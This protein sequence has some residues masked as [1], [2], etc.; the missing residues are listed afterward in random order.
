MAAPAPPSPYLD[1]APFLRY[2]DPGERALVL[3]FA[4]GAGVIEP[5]LSSLGRQLAEELAATLRVHAGFVTLAQNLVAF[6]DGVGGGDDADARPTLKRP[7][8]AVFHS[9]PQ[10][11][12][13]RDVCRRFGASLALTGRL[14]ADGPEL[15]LGLNLIDVERL[16]LLASLH[17]VFTRDA[18][19]A[20]LVEASADLLARFVELPREALLARA[21]EVVGTQSYR[22]L[23]NWAMARD[24]ERQADIDGASAAVGK[25]GTRLLERLLYALED[26][27]LYLPPLDALIRYAA[28][29]HADRD[30][31][32]LR[33]LA[34]G[35]AKVRLVRPAFGMLVAEAWRAVGETAQA[36]EA[37][38]GLVRVFPKTAQAHF[39][40]GLFEEKERPKIAHQHF[41]EALKLDPTRELY[42]RKVYPASE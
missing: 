17:R 14:L 15:S 16:T 34:K 21:A 11:R 35:L 39:M 3:C 27:P 33:Q 38:E 2:I 19:P 29:W 31:A 20:Q 8:F 30:E 7:V 40:L 41:M 4:L 13:V 12:I 23:F 25:Q 18:L 42:R 36:R 26:D 10:T 9:L 22:A 28:Q 5:Q 1:P 32:H 24:I 37:L 6:E